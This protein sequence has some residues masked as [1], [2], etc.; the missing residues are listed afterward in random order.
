M[1]SSAI[2]TLGE[3]RT[4]YVFEETEKLTWAVWHPT[5]DQTNLQRGRS[6]VLSS[7]QA[8]GGR[9]GHKTWQQLKNHSLELPAL[10]KMKK[11]ESHNDYEERKEGTGWRTVVEHRISPKE[12]LK[13]ETLRIGPRPGV[14]KY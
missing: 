11:L 8:D 3:Q 1:L 13:G 4:K 6:L 7:G 5:S 14:S 9:T 2:C 12:S 10:G